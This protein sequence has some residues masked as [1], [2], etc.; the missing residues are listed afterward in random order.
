MLTSGKLKMGRIAHSNLNAE[1]ETQGGK[2]GQNIWMIVSLAPPLVNR[3][4]A[5]VQ[6]NRVM[7]I[8]MTRKIR[9]VSH[10][11]SDSSDFLST[12]PYCETRYG[13]KNSVWSLA[14]KIVSSKLDGEKPSFA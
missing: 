13:Q 11:M 1:T 7:T 8:Q 6:K 5:L 4:T 3:M 12:T 9:R 14:E 2:A 10:N